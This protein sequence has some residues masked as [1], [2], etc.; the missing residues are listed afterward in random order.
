MTIRRRTLLAL[1]AAAPVAVASS[2]ASASERAAVDAFY[3]DFLTAG[4]KDK[5][6]VAAAIF[7]PEWKSVGDYSG[8]AKTAAALTQQVDGLHKLIPD[9]RWSMEEVIQAG[10]KIVVRG[11]ATGTPKGPFFGVDG[12]GRGFAIM[13]IDIHDVANGRIVATH[14]VEDWATALRQLAGK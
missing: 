9:L 1:A 13:S 7:A 10:G 4:P 14:H 12:Q 2:P 6:A 11:K 8:G 3:K 5:A